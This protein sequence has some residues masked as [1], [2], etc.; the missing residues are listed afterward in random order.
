MSYTKI[1][2]IG[3]EAFFEQQFIEQVNTRG[4]HTRQKITSCKLPQFQKRPP[5]TNFCATN[6][7]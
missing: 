6:P 3:Y 5:L 4:Y 2:P 7:K 1:Q